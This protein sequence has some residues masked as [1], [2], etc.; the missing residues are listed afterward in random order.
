MMQMNQNTL[1]QNDL[2][3]VGTLIR[4]LRKRKKIKQTELFHGLCTKEVFEHIESGKGFTDELLIERLLSRLHVQYHLLELTLSDEAFERKEL[5]AAIELCVEKQDTEQAK[6]L[7]QAYERMNHNGNLEL[8]YFLW[9]KA[10]LLENDNRKEAGALYQKAFLL[11][12]A[13]V[14]R[15]MLSSEEVEMYLGYRRC[16]EPLSEKEQTEILQWIEK[17]LFQRQIYPKSYFLIQ[18][19]IAEK[20]YHAEQWQAAWDICEVCISVL[21]SKN[22]TCCLTEFLF[23][24]ARCREKLL[25]GDREEQQEEFRMVYYTCLAFGMVADAEK[26]LDYCREE[27]G[28]DIINAAQ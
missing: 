3:E 1:V 27:P 13:N 9:V 26:V 2:V 17:E 25:A 19:D 8:Q 15:R 5:R 20:Y 4:M 11:T 22:K 18:R 6:Q 7:L 16:L 21:N 10:R 24:R 14:E 23:L 28:W 12:G